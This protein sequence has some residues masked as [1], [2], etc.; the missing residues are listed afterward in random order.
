MASSSESEK[1]ATNELFSYENKSWSE[2]EFDREFG[3]YTEHYPNHEYRIE[4]NSESTITEY[5]FNSESKLPKKTYTLDE[6]K[7]IM[8]NTYQINIY[9]REDP[10]FRKYT[11]YYEGRLTGKGSEI[12]GSDI[13]YHPEDDGWTQD[14]I[15][16]SYYNNNVYVVTYRN[17]II[18]GWNIEKSLSKNEVIERLNEG[19]NCLGY[20]IKENGI[21]TK[22]TISDENLAK[23][24]NPPS[25][26]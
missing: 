1:F 20:R 14:G 4:I 18:D 23:Y 24:G 5:V 8:N 10:N 2:R 26:E 22:N 3:P 12:M 6:L 15:C 16:Y 13:S 9:N 25:L 19:S 7:S 11:R 21:I 17:G